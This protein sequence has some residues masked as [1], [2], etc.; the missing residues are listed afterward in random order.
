[1]L[2]SISMSESS[3]GTPSRWRRGMCR[4]SLSVSL[5]LSLAAPETELLSI[6]FVEGMG[7]GGGV[8]MVFLITRAQGRGFYNLR[9]YQRRTVGV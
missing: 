2:V 9:C 8:N 4:V 3:M 5:C 7:E 6:G 1:M